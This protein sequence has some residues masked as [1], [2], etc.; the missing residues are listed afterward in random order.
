MLLVQSERSPIIATEAY[1]FALAERLRASTKSCLII[2]AYLTADGLRWMADCLPPTVTVSILAR[3]DAAD[4]AAG[5][6]DTAA[7]WLACERGWSFRVLNDL[8]AKCCLVDDET[9]FIGSANITNRG[10]CLSPGGN[11]ELG[12]YAKATDVDRQTAWSLFRCG[13]LLN[14]VVVQRIEA[15][16]K[17][18]AL[19]IMTRPDLTWPREVKDFFAES[20]KGLWVGDLPWSQAETVMRLLRGEAL[21]EHELSDARHDLTLFRANTLDQLAT[22]FRAANCFRWLID[23]VSTEPDRFVFFGRLTERLHSS[24]LD[25][26]KPYRKDV[27]GLV[28]NLITYSA[29]LAPDMLQ[30]DRPN[31]SERLSAVSS[32]AR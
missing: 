20:L 24:L 10:L 12:L 3:W 7:Y 1:R 6:S 16:L 14:D 23:T 11:R 30:Y 29:K 18:L 9:L 31:Y 22:G 4:L 25:D 15:W 13:T 21:P 32:P 5:A 2:S 8:H 26:P 19:P 27:K 17:E 28:S